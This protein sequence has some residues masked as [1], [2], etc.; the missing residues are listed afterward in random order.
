MKNIES[1]DSDWLS[2]ALPKDYR[3]NGCPRLPNGKPAQLDFPDYLVW[4]ADYL[5]TEAIP[6]DSPSESALAPLLPLPPETAF[7]LLGG[8][9]GYDTAE[10]EK[11]PFFRYP[12]PF[13]PEGDLDD[14]LPLHP[15][16]E[17]LGDPTDLDPAMQREFVAGDYPYHLR[18]REE[19]RRFRTLW[20]N[21]IKNWDL[22]GETESGELG[23]PPDAGWRPFL[24]A[25]LQREPDKTRRIALLTL[26][27]E[28]YA[29]AALE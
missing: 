12:D 14:L 9:A 28:E 19:M 16:D 27:F 1:I 3:M 10:C 29:D 17:V 7:K 15:E 13:D 26:F 11:R 21:F 18:H 20:P 6:P 23:E 25:L 22:A 24:A 2:D 8:H 5:F 4:L